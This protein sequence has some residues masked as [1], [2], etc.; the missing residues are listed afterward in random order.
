MK[1]VS[2]KESDLKKIIH[3]SLGKQ[4]IESS[5]PKN[6]LDFVQQNPKIVIEKLMESHGENFFDL[7]GETYSNK[8]NII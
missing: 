5:V 4:L 2:I 7:V 8:K 3:E 1:K 6:V